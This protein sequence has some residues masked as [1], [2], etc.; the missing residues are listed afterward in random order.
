MT[1]IVTASKTQRAERTPGILLCV[2]QQD[3]GCVPANQGVS[4]PDP[5]V[6]VRAAWHGC[7]DT[8][9]CRLFLTAFWTPFGLLFVHYPIGL[10]VSKGYLPRISP[11]E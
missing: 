3:G 9:S 11:S 4:W 7:V 10:G 8:L 2:H 1:T 6:R 5:S